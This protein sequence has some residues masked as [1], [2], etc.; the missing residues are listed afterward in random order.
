MSTK[1]IVLKSSDNESFEVDEAVA[2]ESQTLAHMVEDDCTDNGIPLP[3]VTG[4]ILAKVIEYCKKH[5]DAAAAKTEA[6]ADGG[7]SS[8]DDLKAW[9]AEFMKIDQATLFELILAAN[10]L[11]IKNLLDLTCQTVADMIKGKTPD[12]IRTTF[13]IKNDF[14]PEEEEEVRRENQWA[15]E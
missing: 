10:Y 6:A 2:R 4:K 3:N 8:D 11:N 13:N 5:V 15:F 12:E 1:K 14:S 7:A 9:D